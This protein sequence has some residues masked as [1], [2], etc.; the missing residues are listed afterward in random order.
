MR[1]S[2][3]AM[4]AGV[5]VFALVGAG[6]V[7]FKGFPSSVSVNGL[8]NSS[9]VIQTTL[10]S[11]TCDATITAVSFLQTETDT[12]SEVVV[13][14]DGVGDAYSCLGDT[15]TAVISDGAANVQTF[16]AL[17]PLDAAGET[18]VTVPGFSFLTSW[19]TGVVTTTIS[20]ADPAI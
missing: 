10:D 1:K 6:A 7:G 20:A 17:F 16:T 4:A 13:T 3:L 9:A 2:V 19:V 12:I 11:Y 14:F 18:I 15:I 8:G 5:S